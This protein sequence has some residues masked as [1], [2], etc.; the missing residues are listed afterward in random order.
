[1][2]REEFGML[3]ELHRN[4]TLVA[5]A[6]RDGATQRKWETFAVRA[7]DCTLAALLLIALAPVFAIVAVLVYAN[8]PGPIFFAHRRIGKGGQQFFCY[9]FRSM[10]MDSDERLAKLLS[11]DEAARIEWSRD[12]KLRNDPRVTPL[13]R[14]LRLSSIDELPQLVNVLRGEMSL[15]GPRPIVTSE[16]VRYGRF[17]VDYCSVKPG[18]TGLWQIS[19][20][21]NT[22]YRRRV[23]M[24]V[25]FS[26]SYSIGLYLRI[27]V[28]TPTAIL[29]ARGSC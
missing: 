8:D 9:K 13:G 23:A 12:H 17:F 24:D 5:P 14:F 29:L 20:R 11:S 15:V 22:S 18:I 1:M 26:R 27:I 10:V 16:I 28:Q 6:I 3:L 7:I 2:E 21:S 19:G 25:V 4:H